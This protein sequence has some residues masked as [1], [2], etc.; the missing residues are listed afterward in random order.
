M[1]PGDP[2]WEER[3][4]RAAALAGDD[5]AWRALY[6][7]AFGPLHAFVH[8]RTGRRDDATEEALQECW[9][10]AVRRMRDFDPGKGT[11]EGWLRGIAENVL[12]NRRRSAARE[13]ARTGVD[14]GSAA[15]SREDARGGDLSE[16]IALALTALPARYQ[17]VIRAKYEEDLPVAEIAARRGESP[18]AVESLLSRARAAFRKAYRSLGGE[19]SREHEPR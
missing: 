8:L 1:E 3:A 17:E 9:L 15:G 16:G 19:G 2:N 11:F 6:E 7:R 5:A 10:T 18:K 4:L 14:L 13:R 12:R